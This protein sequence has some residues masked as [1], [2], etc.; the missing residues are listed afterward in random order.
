MHEPS[1]MYFAEKNP[2]NV[3]NLNQP[4]VPIINPNSLI[5]Q[6][7]FSLHI[8]RLYYTTANE[9]QANPFRVFVILSVLENTLQLTHKEQLNPK[10]HAQS[11][12]KVC[13]NT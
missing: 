1:K 9:H 4:L 11:K 6:T 2:E 7:I 12:R 5:T 10:I 8:K 13:N 3:T